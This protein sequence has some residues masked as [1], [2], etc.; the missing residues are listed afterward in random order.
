MRGGIP[1]V[2]T[3]KETR[4][5]EEA[6]RRALRDAGAVMYPPGVPLD[7][8]LLFVVR[9][10]V[11]APRYLT[12]P[13]RRPDLANYVMLA[14]DAGTGV[15]WHDDAQLAVVVAEKRYGER[16]AIHL[17]V[18]PVVMRGAPERIGTSW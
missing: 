9:K 5:A 15:L 17:V 1:F 18:R 2:Y 8:M 11:K 16:P 14:S 6:V 4:R 12:H 7:L 10:P 3:P 13:P